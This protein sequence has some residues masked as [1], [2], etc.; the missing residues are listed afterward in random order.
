MHLLL[1]VGSGAYRGRS[2]AGT[3]ELHEAGWTG[4]LQA[5]TWAEVVPSQ[6]EVPSPW[7]KQT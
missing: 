4:E 7:K 5:C 2:G 3:L 1:G 6:W